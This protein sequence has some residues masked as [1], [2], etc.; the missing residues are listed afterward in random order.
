[1]AGSTKPSFTFYSSGFHTGRVRLRGMPA[2]RL[3]R[4]V[5]KRSRVCLKRM[6][7]GDVSKIMQFCFWNVLE[8]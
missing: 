2:G 6:Y 7:V 3:D 1:M 8:L 4:G 5:L